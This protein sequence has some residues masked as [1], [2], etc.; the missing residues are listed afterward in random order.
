MTG[1]EDLVTLTVMPGSPPKVAWLNVGNAATG[2]IAELLLGAADSIEAFAA[3]PDVGF[4]ALTF[5]ERP[6]N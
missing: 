4:L 1:D 3:H 2:A 5:G 6:G